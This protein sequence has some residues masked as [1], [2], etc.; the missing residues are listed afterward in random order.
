MET[1][2]VVFLVVLSITLGV[3][4]W[5]ARRIMLFFRLTRPAFPV[6]NLGR[7]LSLTLK[8]ALGQQKIF[9]MPVA[10]ILHALVFWGFLVITIGSVEMVIDGL[11]GSERILGHLGWFYTLISAVEMCLPLLC[12]SVSW[13]SLSAACF[14][15][16]AGFTG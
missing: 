16:S 15:E 4:F 13:Y 11:T 10:G 12:S 2:S 6:R 7:R 14:S 8:V 3:F 1:K 9:R 5:S